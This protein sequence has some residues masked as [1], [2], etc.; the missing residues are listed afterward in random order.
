MRSLLLFGSLAV[1]WLSAES[2]RACGAQPEPNL[3]IESVAPADGARGFPRNGAIQ[4]QLKLSPVDLNVEEPDHSVLTIR[5]SRV[6][7]GVESPG[8]LDTFLKS[9]GIVTWSPNE[10]LLANEQYRI[11]VSTT[12][13]PRADIEGA[14]SSITTFTTSDAFSPELVLEGALR[15]SFRV[16]VAPLHE[17]GPCGTCTE[18]GKRPALFADVEM[19]TVSGGFDA[20]GY[21][22][23][24]TLNDAAARMFDGPGEGKPRRASMVVDLMTQLTPQPGTSNKA[25]IEVP[26]E[27][28]PYDACFGFN[29]WDPIGHSQSAQSICV[30]AAQL[31]SALDRRDAGTE[32]AKDD[33]TSS[34]AGKLAA[35]AGTPESDRPASDPAR[36]TPRRVTSGCSVG[37]DEP[38]HSAA[39]IAT[40]LVLCVVWRRRRSRA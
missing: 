12:P 39:S 35:D 6:A 27:D 29:V 3:T 11:E 36:D 13:Q 23:W 5:V 33:P 28:S 18:V 15:A 9:W 38:G 19:P 30:R 4:I 17:C 10:A 1:V 25:T 37:H 24:L 26:V 16:G 14:T 31:D 22:A 2:A 20:Y 40:L 7:D 34:D 32:T 8:T 21:S